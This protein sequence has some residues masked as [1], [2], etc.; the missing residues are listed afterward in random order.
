MTN[1]DMHESNQLAEFENN[2]SA[3]HE[4]PYGG[5]NLDYGTEESPLIS[6]RNLTK[7]YRIGRNRVR[8]L[9]GVSLQVHRG[10]FVAIMGPSGSGKSTFMNLIGCLDRPD[11]GE[12]WLAG[13]PVSRMSANKLA[14]IR[15]Q[16]IGFVFQGFNLLSRATALSNVSL[17]LMYGGRRRKEQQRKSRKM[18]RLLGLKSRI[19]HKPLELSGGQQQRVAIA[20]ALVNEP[21]ILLA[22]EP[23]GNLDS[24]TSA[25][26]MA[27]LQA[28]NDLGLTIVLVTHDPEVA[29]YAKRQVVFRDGRVVRDQPVARRRAAPEFWSGNEKQDRVDSLPQGKQDAAPAVLTATGPGSQQSKIRRKRSSLVASN[30]GSAVSALW[31]N[32]LRSLLTMLGIIIGV[33]A[34]IAAVTLTLGISELLNQ[35]LSSLG[36]NVLNI[37]PPGVNSTLTVADA[38][39]VSHVPHVLHVSPV[40][41]VNG[42][43]VY[44]D[45][46]TNAQVQAVNADYQSIEN[47]KLA[48]GSWFSNEDDQAGLPVA[49]IGKSVADS[50]FSASGVDPIGQKILISGQVFRVVGVLQPKGA[51]AGTNQDNVVFVAFTFASTHLKNTSS[52]D[53]IEVQVDSADNVS[54]AQQSI[55]SLLEQR[56]HLSSGGAASTHGSGGGPGPAGPGVSTGGT[57]N[58]SDDF[59]ILNA[60]QLLQTLQQQGQ[61]QAT[62]LIGIAAISL[63]VGGIGVM[64]IM[65]V[66]VTERT[67]E[68]GVRMAV[69]ARRRH[70]R[71]Q[72]L[73]EALTLSALG[74]LTGILFGLLGGLVLIRTSS[75]GL[76]F[77]LSPSYMLLAFGVSAAVGIVF[78]LYPAI[79][80]SQLDPIV[81]LRAE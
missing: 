63:T 64:N 78:G 24:Q 50:L 29:A 26:I 8:A 39:A 23:T 80:A 65:L 55:T 43:V 60:N 36:T 68:I 61:A 41:M 16:F 47:W 56:H 28:L 15:N 14:D 46:H 62:L 49:V 19:H 52:V 33:G 42:Q 51:Q 71:N 75:Q 38:N 10:E 59:M 34:V 44:T 17:P 79:R 4:E 32:R 27:T 69:G 76:P 70:I 1:N 21:S 74:G 81:A 18:L 31:A 73:I 12:Y 6:V 5:A 66:S 20:R 54:Q 25:E 53:Q 22:D 45:Q 67:R 30:V 2:I 11:S 9:Q 48:E 40:L 3:A 7:V 57:G 72:F 35:N 13:I 58:S 77:V 37:S